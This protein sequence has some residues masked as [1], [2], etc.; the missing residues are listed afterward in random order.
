MDSASEA[1]LANLHRKSLAG[2]VET[3]SD[4]S[5]LKAAAEKCGGALKPHHATTDWSEELN[6]LGGHRVSRRER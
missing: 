3:S 6:A 1:I 5:S 4:I 2:P